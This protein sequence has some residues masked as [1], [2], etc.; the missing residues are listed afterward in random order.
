MTA[1]DYQ[2]GFRDGVRGVLRWML[3]NQF[4]IDFPPE[5]MDWVADRVRHES[6]LLSEMKEMDE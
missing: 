6:E 2:E 4:S 5:L 3:Q 1:T